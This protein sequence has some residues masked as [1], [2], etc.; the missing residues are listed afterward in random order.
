MRALLTWMPGGLIGRLKEMVSK[1]DPLFATVSGLITF[2][3]LLFAFLLWMQSEDRDIRKL[4]KYF[5]VAGICAVILVTLFGLL[6]VFARLRGM[7]WPV[8]IG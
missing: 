5:L 6:L 7:A 2:V 8:G 1:A 3:A 4:W